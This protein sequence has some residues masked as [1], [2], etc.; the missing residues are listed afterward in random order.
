MPFSC[1]EG[2]WTKASQLIRTTNAIVPAPGQDPEARMVLSYSGKAPHMVLP[3]KGGEFCCDSNCPNWRAM[4]ICSHTVAVAEIN[5]KLPQFLSNA[6]RSKGVNVTKLLTTTMPR[7]RGRKGSVAPCA[8]KPSQSV[9]TRIEMSATAN[10]AL[11]TPSPST[12]TCHA[13]EGGSVYMPGLGSPHFN[14]VQ[15]PVHSPLNFYNSYPYP[16]QAVY[17]PFQPDVQDA[18]NPYP[19]A[20]SYQLSYNHPP[21]PFILCFIQGNISVCIGCKNKYPKAPKPPQ[22]LCI[23]HEEW[24][25]FTPQNTAIPQS[26]FGNVYYHCRMECIWMRCPNFIPN[27]LHIP[28][29]VVENLMPAHKELLQSMFGLSV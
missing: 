7:G 26:K 3:K 19:P 29:E 13:H 9:A 27:D 15:S 23:K 17:P 1:L 24:R 16:A 8:R 14:M 21:L 5:N 20:H 6:K 25:Q 18:G 22:D 4:G 11:E 2:V 28:P 10:S 12:V